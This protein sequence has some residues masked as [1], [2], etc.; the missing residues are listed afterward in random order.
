MPNVVKE[1]IWT[2]K[3]REF[4]QTKSK[5]FILI[6]YGGIRLT[7][8]AISAITHRKVSDLQA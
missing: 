6:N 1:M 4:K 3:W 8:Y 7:I 2:D 5:N